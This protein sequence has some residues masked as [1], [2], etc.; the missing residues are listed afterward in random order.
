MLYAELGRKPLDIHVKSRMIGYWISLVNNDNVNKISRKI[1]DIMCAAYSR[2]QNFK[3]LDSIKQILIS[4]GEPGLFDQ[5]FIP[6]P[7]ATK[8]KI[9]RRLHDL[10]TQEW[11]EKLQISSKGRNYS[12]FK[13]NPNFEFYLMLPHS[14]YLPIVKF[15]TSNYKLPVETGRWH[16]IPLN[17]R[18]CTLCNQ[19]DLGDDMHYLLKCSFF[20]TDRRELLKPY[21][22]TRPNM[23]KLQNLLT[24]NN[25]TVLAK[26]SKFMKLIMN[27]FSNET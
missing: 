17:E 10:Y 2:G 25:K 5:N 18:K 11:S 23:I 22:Y 19:N 3:W 9:V 27:K 15:R 21:Y 20:D 6:N 12:V 16:N 4:V 24:C 8:A 13:Q 26:L 14:I 7:K 1:Y